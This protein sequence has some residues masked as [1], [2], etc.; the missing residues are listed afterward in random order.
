MSLIST[1]SNEGQEPFMYQ[2][3]YPQPITIAPN[4]QICL[5]KFF[6]YRGGSYQI[7]AEN[8]LIAFRFGSGNTPATSLD[9]LRYAG[10]TTGAYTGDQLATELARA[11]NEVNQ[12]Q[13]Y[14]W[15]ATFTEGIGA[16]PDQ[17]TITYTSP[18]T[19][20]RQAG[21]YQEYEQAL[22][23][24]TITG[25]GETA[26]SFATM[27]YEGI[28]GDSAQ[29]ISQTPTLTFLGEQSWE[30]IQLHKDGGAIA[31]QSFKLTKLGMCRA[32]IADPDD[33][34]PNNQFDPEKQDW[35]VSF[36]NNRVEVLYGRQR[37]GSVVGNPDWFFTSVRRTLGNAWKQAVF[38]Q[39]T[40]RLKITMTIYAT[41]QTARKMIIQ[42]FKKEAGAETY[43]AIAD[44]V[45][46]NG[47]N[48]QPLVAT[49]TF[50]ADTFEGVIYDSSDDNF[51]DE[52]NGLPT[53]MLPKNAPFYSTA[54]FT[55]AHTQVLGEYELDANTWENAA[56]T[57]TYTFLPLALSL[58]GYT[59]EVSAVGDGAIDG[60]YWYQRD[61]LFY[62]IMVGDVPLTTPPT[63][64]GLL[65]PT[66]NGGNGQILIRD[67]T[68]NALFRTINYSGLTP[69]PETTETMEVKT[70]GIFNPIPTLLGATD[71][72]FIPQ[73]ATTAPAAGGL[74]EDLNSNAF[75]L[76]NEED[77]NIGTLLGM[78]DR[79]DF[80]AGGAGS[81]GSVS[82][83]SAPDQTANNKTLHIS[84][85]EMPLV[86]SY[87]GENA[88]EG[89]SL[90]IIPR[91]EFSTGAEFGSLVYVAPYENWVNINNGQELS[92]N[93][94][95][96]I[97][98]NADGTLAS[99]LRNQTQAVFKIRQDPAK[100]E[101]DKQM[102]RNR[103]MAEMLA[104]TINTGITSLI[105][106]QQLIG[107]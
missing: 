59:W 77:A 23:D 15:G 105:T 48:G 64:V 68:T 104:N 67:G 35:V 3:H 45:G 11:M 8:N 84:L 5:Q 36:I 27:K 91:D 25:T 63:Y 71:P 40:D 51:Q 6:H 52:G 44:G 79:H 102:E 55:N 58:N 12:Q 70:Q 93:L 37:Q 50:G 26:N 34:N 38:T 82:S 18:A 72:N 24:L 103:M 1:S 94:L 53:T 46:G 56:Q 43:T 99:T 21:F 22:G 95:T 57:N 106:P 76:F 42:A 88:Q 107:S 2:N 49:K 86:K 20:D 92:I 60:T 47:S 101:E 66:G 7:T 73:H 31:D 90:A 62:E 74:L 100:V 80:N 9:V 39:E 61:P 4:S 75:I 81:T 78:P 19:P 28:A 96:T 65:D 97:V 33:A 98:R 85:P 10:L 14:L 54:S 32:V 17:F 69:V 16:N 29:A 13:N 41:A 89:K 87:E 83:D 30:D